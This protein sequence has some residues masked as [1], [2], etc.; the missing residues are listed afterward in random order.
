M[1][2]PRTDRVAIVVKDLERTASFYTNILGMQ[3]HPMQFGVDATVN[4][5]I[6]G[7]KG[8]F[9]DANGLW[10]ALIQP[11]G[12]GPLMDYLEEKGDGHIAELIVEVD[13]LAAYY[14]EMKANGVT[15]NNIDG[16]PLN[17]EKKFHVLEPYGDKLAYLPEQ[18]S[19]GIT[20][21]VFERGP[22]ETSLIHQ[23][24]DSWDR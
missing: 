5:S 16:T 13:D 11:V 6:G 3:R 22:R 24:D 8:T 1:N 10:L 4:Q 2:T 18:T 9:I 21:E 19:C 23:R 12:P 15:L 14:D 20:I 17:N 7:M